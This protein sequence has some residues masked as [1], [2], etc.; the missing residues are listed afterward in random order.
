MNGLPFLR[1]LS[2][3]SKALPWM[4]SLPLGKNHQVS[5]PGLV[6]LVI[7]YKLLH[8]W[9]FIVYMSIYAPDEGMA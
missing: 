8:D 2:W 1:L 7:G 6:G 3:S 5:T 4:I 9:E